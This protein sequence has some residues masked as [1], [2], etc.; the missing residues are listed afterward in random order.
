MFRRMQTLSVSFFVLLL[1]VIA[2]AQGGVATG[3][4]HV[5]VKDPKGNIVTNAS[6]N[7]QDVAKGLERSATSDGQ[8]GYNA[9]Q[10]P[11]GN[12]TVTVTVPGFTRVQSTGVSITVGGLVEL[13][14][15]LSVAG[16]TEVVEV[17]SQA[18]LIETSRSS[19]TNTIG[20]R[21]I[22][23]L[24]INGRN[25]INFTLT[26]S[27]VVR[28]NAPNTG[29][30]PTS[31]LNMSG[32]RARS[33]LVNV[34]GADATDNSVNGVRSTVSQEA[35][36]E[37]QIITNNYA[38]EYGR[39]AGGVVNII[40]RSGSNQFHGDVFG[41][42]RNRAFQ[43]V[44][45]FSTVANP[46][47]TRVQAGVAFGGP[48]KKDKTYYFFSYEITR[49]HETGFSSIGQDGYGLIP[50]DASPFF[51]Q[52]PGTVNL[53]LHSGQLAFLADPNV[54][55]AVAANPGGPYALE[56][57]KYLTLAGASSGM[58]VNGA[59]PSGL[60]GVLTGGALSTFSGF[61][62]TCPPP[63]P[64]FVPGSYRTLESQRG[65]FPVF[66]GTSL[67]SLRLDHNI[68]V[69]HRLTF[70]AN[71]SPS[72]VTGIEV[73][74]QDQPFG[75][76]AY[77]RT[78]E[79]TY[80]DVAGMA[81]DT[82]T[83]GNNKVNEFRFQYARRGLSYFYNTHTSDGSTPAIN[84]TG[85]A[86]FGREP[87]S[88]IQ[89]TEQRYQFTDNFSWTMGRHNTKFGVDVNYLPL[90]AIFTVNYG[91]VYDF[92]AFS[93][94]TLGFVNP[95]PQHLPN[96]PD[97]NSVQ[98]YGAGLP[99]DLVQGLGSPKDSFRNIPIGAFWQDSWR[100]NSHVT[101]NYGVR[102]DVEVPPTFKAP[103]GLAA[104]AYG[105]LGLQKGI[106]TDKNNIQPRIGMALDPKGD[107]KT[108]VR[109]S[110]G[111]FYD[112][113]LL[114]LYFLGDASDGSSSGQLA[115][116]PGSACKGAGNP[117]NLNAVEAFQGLIPSATGS[118]LSPCSPTAGPQ[119]PAVLGLL[120][121]S[122]NN[123]LFSCTSAGLNCGVASTTQ[124]I[125][126][127]QNYLNPSTFFPLGFQPFGYPQSH[128]FVYAYSQQ[129][130]VSIE[131][132]LGHGFAL[133]L[134][135]NFN[136]GRHLNRP[137]NANTIRGDL[138]VANLNAAIIDAT[139]SGQTLPS[140]PF[141]VSGCSAGGSLTIPL[142]YVD[143][144]L[145]NFFRPGGLN[146]SII[147][148]Y[149]LIEPSCI[150]QAAALAQSLGF[151][152]CDP[153]T[154]AGCVPFGDMDANY[155]NGSSVYH[156]FS[157]NLRKRFS[158]HYE[159]LASYTYS[160]AIDDSTDL[161]STLTPQD[162]YYP[163]VDRST[164]LFDQR[165]RFVFSG[166]YQTGKLSGKG[167][168][169]KV[170]SDWTFAP[171]LE[172][173]SGRP[174]NI[175][176]G[177]G[178]NLQL[179]SLTSRPNVTVDPAC[180]TPVKSKYS[181]TGVFQEPCILGFLPSATNPLGTTPTLLQLDGNLGRN[182]GITP[183]TAFGDMRVSKRVYFTERFSADFIVDMFNI[184]NKYN[185]AAVSPL[186]TNAGQPTAAYD[187]RQF[188]F[189]MK[190]NW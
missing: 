60:V 181:P 98:A 129:A 75:Q 55:A 4:L 108:V 11:P 128:N 179:S 1:P 56:V 28:D 64:C 78:S 113:P 141:T 135:Y 114:G 136:G 143:A 157:T 150:P 37:F 71:V 93:S 17:T 63:G 158:T 68:G 171:L 30:A 9:R 19:T 42:L 138:M 109:A 163:A 87:Y 140:S 105:V 127:G 133:N 53:Q 99:G 10:L 85:V 77:S 165:H 43:A 57:G 164:S 7:V 94:A 116:G 76:N 159:F 6:V 183:W 74:G 132:D 26:D 48:I 100:V 130:N 112:H 86:Y 125:F 168:A 59:W 79:Q 173:G 82:W 124:S 174:F 104:P 40:T 149:S 151:N 145:M 33:N 155:S 142:P 62:S 36:Q 103:Q 13:P 107:G 22:D 84:I 44:N 14:I 34:D 58:A 21:R 83:I 170:F 184:A 18:E 97:L 117:G 167:F 2:H 123:Q 51:G 67:Y 29:A 41:Y 156:G 118:S 190:V 120:N 111:M 106:Q 65:N 90:D 73:S 172:I 49:R 146:P 186:F 161:Q 152:A 72:T 81:Q 134:A 15:S 80:R 126:L 187:P 12:Y 52:A 95:D 110:Y 189:A 101:L 47:Y 121:Y 137:I 122:P 153:T 5:T 154:F 176:T 45:P 50:F 20:E 89:R 188:Q 185:V 102:Y 175:L 119:G 39:A 148:L 46:A 88:Y 115:F 139:L 61:P 144:S 27:Q 32:Q 54:Q 180:G 69:N 16:T 182:A 24:P 8:G 35:V 169:S 178:D 38:A 131:R 70:R 177:G 96:F 23:N 91:G 3:D 92:G 147:G 66:E 31:G 160:H 25:Y 162:S 166:V